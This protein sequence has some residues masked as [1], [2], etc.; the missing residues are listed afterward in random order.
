MAEIN[1]KSPHLKDRDVST[2]EFVAEITLNGA[3][4][5]TIDIPGLTLAGTTTGFTL[6]GFECI[7]DLALDSNRKAGVSIITDGTVSALPANSDYAACNPFYPGDIT[8]KTGTISGT[9]GSRIV[10]WDVDLGDAGVAL[11]LTADTIT[12]ALVKFH[13]PIK[14]KDFS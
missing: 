4:C 7:S 9:A 3:C 1:V 12:G 10:T 13:L 2:Y 8:I 5:S 11:D 6:S 14:A